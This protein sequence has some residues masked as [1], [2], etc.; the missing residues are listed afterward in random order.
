M[1]QECGQLRFDL[2][3]FLVVGSMFSE[4]LFN[5]Q[6]Y[7]A[8]MF[9]LEYRILDSRGFPQSGEPPRAKHFINLSS[10]VIL[11]AVLMHWLKSVIQAE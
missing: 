9:L 11:V 3:A 10:I 6:M 7:C 1:K 8:Q 2:T 4:M 5:Q